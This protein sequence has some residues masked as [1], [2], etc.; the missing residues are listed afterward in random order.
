MV[1]RKI[2][3]IAA[4]PDDEVL[5]CGGTIAKHKKNGDH[6]SVLIMADG[7]NS[8][9][10]KFQNESILARRTCAQKAN[11]LLEVDELVFMSFPDNQMDTLPLLEIIKSIE[12]EID[13]LAPDTVYTHSLSDLNIDHQVVHNATITACRPLPDQ[14]VNQLLFFEIPSSTEWKISSSNNVFNPNWFSDISETLDLK[15]DALSLYKS[16][17]REFPHP[18]SLDAVKSLAKWRGACAGLNAAE[19]FELGRMKA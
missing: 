15:L 10:E 2:L 18:R 3:V 16:E 13:R 12:I 6:V 9:E 11:N 8:R 17:V 19:A 14:S 4:H 5:G 1:K 7:V